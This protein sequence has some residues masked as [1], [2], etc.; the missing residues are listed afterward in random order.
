[1]LCALQ[2][3][4]WRPKLMSSSQNIV[5]HLYNVMNICLN[6]YP[7]KC[8]RMLACSQSHSRWDCQ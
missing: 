5:Q 2:W 3:K 4:V 8:N 1:M 6:A 7:V